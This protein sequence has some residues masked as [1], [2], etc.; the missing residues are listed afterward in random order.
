MLREK[1][2]KPEADYII[3]DEIQDFTESEINEFIGAAKV[4]YLFFGDSA[5]SIYSQ[6]GKAT[7]NI[8][9]ISKLTG[10]TPLCLYNNYRLP[11]PIAKITQTYVGV[12]VNPYEDKVYK[13]SENRL[14]HIIKYQNIDEQISAIKTIIDKNANS[15]Y[16]SIGILLPNNDF[17][18]EICNKLQMQGVTVE[19]KYNDDETGEYVDTLDFSA[20]IP[21]I[22]TYHSAKGLQFD[23][24]VLPMYSGA[25]DEES[26]KALYV[27]MTRTMHK[28][29]VLYSTPTLNPPLSEVPSML[30]LKA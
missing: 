3:V 18:V 11:R 21:K 15:L 8:E 20:N 22:L 14:P 30:Y 10:L 16:S 28:L 2:N 29:Y 1:L 9:Q 27:A 4:A 19:F 24:V 5:Q 25:N 17:V 12:D 6:Y 7:M 13:N 23:T 26:R